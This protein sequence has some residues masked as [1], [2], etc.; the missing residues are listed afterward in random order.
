MVDKIIL[1][2]IQ[3]IIMDR[4]N[5][6]SGKVVGNVEEES[7]NLIREYEERQKEKQ[8]Q[9]QQ[10]EQPSTNRQRYDHE[11]NMRFGYMFLKHHWGD[12]SNKK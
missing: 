12:S 1:L 4:R 8:K 3:S 5:D 11:A 2:Y 9:P 7:K 6:K 10:K